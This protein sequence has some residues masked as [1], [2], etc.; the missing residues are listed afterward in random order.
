MTTDTFTP[1]EI[2]LYEADAAEARAGYSVEFLDSCPKLR[3]RGHP[4]QVGKAPAVMV[5]LRMDPDRL[6]AVDARA[7]A[8]RKTRSQFI[9]DAVDREL[10]AV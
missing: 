2:A 9:R 10:L 7:R 5:R 8:E 3:L 1:E 4:L 6:R